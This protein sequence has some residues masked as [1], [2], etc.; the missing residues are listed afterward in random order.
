MSGS[1]DQSSTHG[2]YQQSGSAT[3]R[4]QLEVPANCGSWRGGTHGSG[5]F[6][7]MAWLT[8]WFWEFTFQTLGPRGDINTGGVDRVDVSEL[9]HLGHVCGLR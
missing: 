6:L 7:V 4:R 1:T 8:D 9:G 2:T 5:L 3:P